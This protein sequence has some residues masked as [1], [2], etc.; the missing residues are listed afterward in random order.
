MRAPPLTEKFRDTA[1]PRGLLD[2]AQ[3]VVTVRA[4]VVDS[5]PFEHDVIRV[6]TV[7]G[8][9]KVRDRQT[10]GALAGHDLRH[11]LST[12]FPECHHLVH[13]GDLLATDGKPA[14]LAVGRAAGVFDKTITTFELRQ[15]EV[16]V[17]FDV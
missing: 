3:Y 10:V 5:F 11:A 2:V 16:E 15:G 12:E 8:T 14:V 4:F 6:A 13:V 7:S 17:R 1:V 9:A